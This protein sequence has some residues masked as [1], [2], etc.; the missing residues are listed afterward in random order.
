[1][2]TK[3]RYITAILL[4]SFFVVGAF[5]GYYMSVKSLSQ[6]S[7][8]QFIIG[9]NGQSKIDKIVNIIKNK[10]VDEINTD[11][12]VESIIPSLLSD[13]DP[14]SVYIS[15]ENMKSVNED[16][17]GDF[18]GI[19]IQFNLFEDTIMVV[20]VVEDGPSEK[21]GLVWGDRIVS[22]NDSLVAGVNMNSDSIMMLLRG[23]IGTK[24]KL[25]IKSRNTNSIREVEVTR[26][27][28]PISSIDAS[29]FINDTIGYIKI[30]RFSEVTDKE[31]ARDVARLIQD[32]MK[33]LIVDLRENPGGSLYSVINTLDLFLE[34]DKMILFTEGAHQEK[35]IARASTTGIF[36]D[37][38]VNVI[39]SSNSA[40][41]SEIFAG[42]I[43]D[44]DI[45]YVIG[46]RS[47]GKGLVQ[48]QVPLADG[49]AF[50]I[51][52]ARY[53]IPSGR[54]IQKPYEQGRN[55]YTLDILHRYEH[56]ELTNID[57][58]SIDSSQLF[59][60]SKGRKV[61]GGGGI[62]PDFFVPIDTNGRNRLLD[63]ALNDVKIYKYALK[64]VDDNLEAIK[65]TC[66]DKNI[67]EYLENKKVL[68]DFLNSLKSSSYTPSVADI[69]ESGDLIKNY[70]YAYI[71]RESIGEVAFYKTLYRKDDSLKKAL[72][73]ALKGIKP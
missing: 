54:C 59:Y 10:Y 60:T 18:G 62:M 53:Y 69:K 32:G 46:Q 72:E 61:Y 20:G 55:E 49:S 48:T 64:Y 22:V 30:N 25:G 65:N 67:I 6:Y 2:K 29:Y 68:L 33:S 57:S 41:A 37:L 31:F 23:E 21:S 35:E 40:S 5:V 8:Q 28:I 3:N 70:L 16:M 12:I 27:I 14:H 51:T 11:S 38:S 73:I 17:R 9:R 52:T 42:A 50:R 66:T 63:S 24:V 15:A 13:L 58:I 45:G 44:N 56:G 71:T 26:G 7:H 47:F 43:Q 36:K 4:T 1:M 19:G 39:I 34:K